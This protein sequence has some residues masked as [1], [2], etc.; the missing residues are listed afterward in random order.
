MTYAQH[1]T[2]V[3]GTSHSVTVVPPVATV[4][5]EFPVGL[6]VVSR[7]NNAVALYWCVHLMHHTNTHSQTSIQ[8]Q[9]HYTHNSQHSRIRSNHLHKHTDS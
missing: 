7:P 5:L 9:Q 8:L 1:S 4:T 2:I 3:S 6:R